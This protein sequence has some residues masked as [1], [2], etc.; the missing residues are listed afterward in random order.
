VH[1]VVEYDCTHFS[2]LQSISSLRTDAVKGGSIM[3]KEQ[4][5]GTWKLVSSEFRLS[6]GQVTYPMGRDAIGIIMYDTNWHVSVQIMRPD[7]PAF[8]SGDQLKGTPM[9]I[10]SAF[11]GFVAY[12]GIYEVNE[13]KGIVT[14]HLE[15]SLFP[16]WVGT[17]QRRFFKFSGN[18]LTLSTPPILFGGQQVTV[19]LIWERAE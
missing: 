3:G 1:C 2:T 7:R 9:E 16:N 15:G 13:E 6:N 4:F 14:H 18:R 17:D 5:I 19:V 10:K 11:E 12:Y 8:A